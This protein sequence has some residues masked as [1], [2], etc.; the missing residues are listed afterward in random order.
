VPKWIVVLCL[1]LATV[2]V[3][4]AAA[5]RERPVVT[6]F[7]F[8]PSTFA[9]GSGTTISFKLSHRA[10]VKISFA[11][12][13]A[14]RMVRRHCVKP[15]AKLSRRRSCTRRVSSGQLVARHQAAG[16][17]SLA[18]KGRVGGRLLP[19]GRYH[20]TIVAVDRR[21]H[22][23]R[24]KSAGFILLP[25]GSQPPGSGPGPGPGPNPPSPPRP[26]GTPGG[27]PN[28]STTGT[29]AG[30]VPARVTSSDIHVS[31]PGA[32][33][34][35]V[36]LQNANIFVEAP[37]V[38][39]RRVKLQGGLIDNRPGGFGCQN[40]MVVEDTTIEPPPGQNAQSED[41]W[42]LGTGGYTARRVYMRNVSDGFRVGGRADGGCAPVSIE[43][44]FI[45]VAPPVP[46][47]DWHGDGIQGYDGPALAVHNVTIDMNEQGCGGTAPFFYPRNQGN[48]SATIDRL[49]V[50]GGGYSFR[51][52][53]PGSVSGLKIVTRGWS[54]GPIDVYCSAISSWD[55][56]LVTITADYQIA[57]TVRSQPCNSNGGS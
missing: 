14:G 5:A 46:C 45:T 16:Q 19:A 8:S 29:P 56:S 9:R 26:P 11:R 25:R 33:V 22:R 54:C 21:H 50:K 42:R 30:W 27:F 36:L 55:A 18:F 34:Q 43:D 38:T 41:H 35:D 17:R 23:S 48:T 51:D 15:A 3:P 20:A 10:T 7:S 40:G 1:A 12:E 32:V 47:G 2:V 28:A 52:G 4:Q 44:T 39:I 24:P 57:S 53:M 31:Q 13:L 49:L 37:N 6:G